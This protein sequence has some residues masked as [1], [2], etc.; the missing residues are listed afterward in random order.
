MVIN[1]L[2]QTFKYKQ[3]GLTFVEVMVALFILVTGILG[4]VALQAT[5]KQSS[6]DAMQRSIASS[7]TQDIIERMR[8]NDPLALEVYEGNYGNNN[9]SAAAV[10]D[11]NNLC[12]PA[13]MANRDLFEWEQA[14]MGANVLN[15]T[16]NVGGLV[17]VVG[18]IVHTNNAVVVTVSWQGKSEL[19][20]AKKVDNCGTGSNNRRQVTAEVFIF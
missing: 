2:K 14:I 18:C 3:L 6:F 1:H 19:K 16:T 10:C 4:A 12:N 15:G 7:L 20:D 9:A 13:N 8:N 5:A 11:E 17:G